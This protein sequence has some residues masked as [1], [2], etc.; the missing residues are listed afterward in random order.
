[1][2]KNKL[3]YNH[4][5]PFQVPDNYFRD[6]EDRLMEKVA[7]LEHVEKDLELPGG[8][9]NSGFNVPEDYFENI[10]ERVMA[11]LEAR[12]EQSKV[13]S[14]LNKEVFYYI[15]GAAAVFV[16]I[17][18]TLFTN[19]AQPVGFEDLDLVTIE[20]YLHETLELSTTDVS[21]YFS[22]DEFSF[23]PSGQTDVNQEAVIDYLREN[24]EEPSMLFNEE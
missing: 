18:T 10:E 7:S 5:N 20:G 21:R 23:A 13:I 3:P 1:M 4:K 2:K 8:K 9:A 6:L 17:I 12:P 19:P 14:L 15:A 11:K 16:A 24:I 22:E